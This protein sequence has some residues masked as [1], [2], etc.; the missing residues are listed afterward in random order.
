MSGTQ[1]D[2]LKQ[3]QNNDTAIWHLPSKRLATLFA[4]IPQDLT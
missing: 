2:I 3:D 4:R 1:P